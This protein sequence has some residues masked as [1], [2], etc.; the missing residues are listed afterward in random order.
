MDLYGFIWIHMYGHGC[1]M[2]LIWI[3]YGYIRIYMDLNRYIYIYMDL[4][5]IYYGFNMD[6]SGFIRI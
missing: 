6:L 4:I 5:W 3:Q 1:D 2:D